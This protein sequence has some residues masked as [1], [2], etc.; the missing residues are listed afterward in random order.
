MCE[1]IV[2]K[3][4]LLLCPSFYSYGEV[5]KKAFEH[6]G[7]SVDYFA[8]SYAVL[9]SYSVWL[10]IIKK[11][12]FKEYRH[13]LEE[14]KCEL[15]TLKHFSQTNS[16]DILFVIQVYPFDYSYILELRKK[17]PKIKTFIYFWD[18][19]EVYNLINVVDYFDVVCSF[20]WKDVQIIRTYLNNCGNNKHVKYLPIFYIEDKNAKCL[21]DKRYDLSFV[22]TVNVDTLER[23]RFIK[24]MD[25]WCR[26]NHVKSFLYLRY[27]PSLK[28]TLS[29]RT[30]LSYCVNKKYRRYVHT[31]NKYLSDN[32][33]RFM[34][35]QPLSLEQVGEIENS[36]NCILDIAH[37]NRQGYT[38]N[39]ITAVAK[40]KKLIT[41]NVY[42]KNEPFFQS[43][44]I[45]VVDVL[46]PVFDKT[47]FREPSS[48]IDI[49]CLEVNNWIFMVLD[50]DYYRQEIK[51]VSSFH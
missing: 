37:M 23:C 14:I 30:V 48:R 33:V 31:L 24:Q 34:H 36:S 26:V 35:A 44:N 3:R 13:N 50:D 6:A 41:T 45:Y 32:T 38:I 27:L 49:S 11:L 4:V 28:F 46:N 8:L 1:N 40:G 17:N 42:I 29:I 25:E 10:N 22:G 51:K 12:L 20:N 39:A 5:I 2:G 18:S 15:E 43:N 47:F 16:Y 7:A 19:F 21:H 9:N